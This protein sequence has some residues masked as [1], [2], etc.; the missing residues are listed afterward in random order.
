MA[1]SRKEQINDITWQLIGEEREHWLHLIE[2]LEHMQRVVVAFSGG[3]DSAFLAVAAWLA[4]GEDM[5]AVTIHSPVHIPEDDKAAETVAKQ[6]GF[7]HQV[8]EHDDLA[9]AAFVAN[10]VNRCYYCK[11]VRF[12]LLKDY[13][14]DHGYPVMIEGSNADDSSA[15]RPGAKASKELQVRSPLQEV[16]YHKTEI[17]KVSKL[18]GIPVWNRPSSP[19][20]AT[21]IPFGTPITMADLMTVA[22]AEDFLKERGFTNIRVRYQQP[23]ARIEVD[24]AQVTTLVQHKEEIIAAF[25]PFGIKRVLVD[26]EGYRSGKLTEDIRS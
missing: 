22:K 17:R 10:P 26:L 16:G 2:R 9:D 24:P 5:L 4:L 14:I 3:I 15:D 13:A 25:K 20:L 8:I 12:S 18:L 23:I 21:R 6:F 1:I 7:P 19:C 11:K